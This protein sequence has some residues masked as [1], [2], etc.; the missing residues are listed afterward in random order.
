MKPLPVSSS[1]SSSRVP[2]KARHAATPPPLHAKSS[3]SSGSDSTLLTPAMAKLGKK[4]ESNKGQCT[5][6]SR[7]AASFARHCDLSRTALILHCHDCFHTVR[8]MHSLT[9]FVCASDQIRKL[10]INALEKVRVYLSSQRF[11]LV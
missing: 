5:C 3:A 7:P 8:T 4:P 1:S 2:A 11:S 9:L 6:T 10:V